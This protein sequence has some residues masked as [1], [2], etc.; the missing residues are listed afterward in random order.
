MYWRL[1]HCDTLGARLG[2]WTRASPYGSDP[3]QSYGS[4][5]SLSYGF[6]ARQS[7]PPG[8]SC[9]LGRSSSSHTG[10]SRVERLTVAVDLLLG[11]LALSC[12]PRVTVAGPEVGGDCRGSRDVSAVARRTW[13][14]LP[15]RAKGRLEVWAEGMAYARTPARTTGPS[16]ARHVRELQGS[17]ADQCRRGPLEVVLGVGEAI[18]GDARARTRPRSRSRRPGR[19]ARERRRP[20][21]SCPRWNQTS[22]AGTL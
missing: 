11:L 1:R 18:V 3:S 14:E 15:E 6:W 7:A 8:P 12:L 19:G 5:P 4:D 21:R 13:D 16:L 9:S 10:R 20:S 22:S 2:G 17:A